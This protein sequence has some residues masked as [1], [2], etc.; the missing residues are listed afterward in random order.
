MHKGENYF[1]L[2]RQTLVNL[3]MSSFSIKVIYK[4]EN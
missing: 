2:N 1:I 3:N 4:S